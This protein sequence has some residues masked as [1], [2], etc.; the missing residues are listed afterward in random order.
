M[1]HSETCFFFFLFFPLCQKS[2]GVFK[3][4]QSFAATGPRANTFW[5][6]A[7][8]WTE[9]R[10]GLVSWRLEV[11]GAGEEGEVGFWDQCTLI[12]QWINQSKPWGA[13]ESSGKRL[14]CFVWVSPYGPGPASSVS[15]TGSFI[16]SC[17]QH[18]TVVVG[19]SSSRDLIHTHNS[20]S[21]W[22]PIVAIADH[23]FKSMISEKYFGLE[24]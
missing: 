1:R 19:P 6:Q 2:C 15:V 11:R 23:S 3:E 18:S 5:Q 9:P 13:A 21:T 24:S 4:C 12:G 22:A 7:D 17:K 20:T 8:E 14:K 10:G 16:Y